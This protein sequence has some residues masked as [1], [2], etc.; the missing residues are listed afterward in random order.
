[1]S[2]V[3]ARTPLDGISNVDGIVT[4]RQQREAKLAK[5]DDLVKGAV[6][7]EKAT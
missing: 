2:K 6:K 3:Q 1:M 5:R 7:S 4:R